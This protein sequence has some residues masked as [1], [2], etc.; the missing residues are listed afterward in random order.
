MQVAAILPRTASHREGNTS[1]PL[2]CCFGL[3]AVAESVSQVSWI[4]PAAALNVGF[5]TTGMMHGSVDPW[6]LIQLGMRAGRWQWLLGYLALLIASAGLLVLAPG[7]AV[8][9][10]L[11]I[12]A[13]HFGHEDIPADRFASASAS[14]V[15]VMGRGLLVVGIPIALHR[16]ESLAFLAL[17]RDMATFGEFRLPI[18]DP[19]SMLDSTWMTGAMFA[20]VL[21]THAWV[22]VVAQGQSRAWWCEAAVLLVCATLMHPLF[23]LGL[24]LAAWHAVKSSWKSLNHRHA[25]DRRT[26][27]MATAAA[28]VP[29]WMLVV[30]LWW[31]AELKNALQISD[32]LFGDAALRLAAIVF[33]SY[34]IVTTPHLWWHLRRT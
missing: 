4:A 33:L 18:L 20:A 7:V 23:F 25:T 8:T 9:A 17:C 22:A 21:L 32:I 3:L 13:V 6:Q 10:F 11:L 1:L 14:I 15:A 16:E 34:A 19:I 29:I 27:L 12:A 2:L 5:F 26:M 30:F 31:Q 28:T 24:Y